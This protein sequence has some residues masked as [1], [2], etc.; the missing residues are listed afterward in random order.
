M[1]HNK[2]KILIIA[3]VIIV[4]CAFVFFYSI[5][6]GLS[7]VSVKIDKLEVKQDTLSSKVILLQKEYEYHNTNDSIFQTGILNIAKINAENINYLSKEK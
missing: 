4:V 1:E 6:A 7:D 2:N 5:Y 3:N